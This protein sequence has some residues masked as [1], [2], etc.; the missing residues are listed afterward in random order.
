VNKRHIITFLM[1][2]IIQFLFIGC[3]DK[4]IDMGNIKTPDEIILDGNKHKDKILSLTAER[5]RLKQDGNNF[6]QLD[7]IQQQIMNLVV[8]SALYISDEEFIS[9]LVS[10]VKETKGAVKR[11]ID[12]EDQKLIENR[13]FF[14]AQFMYSKLQNIT[15]EEIKNGYISNITIL[16][17]GIAYVPSFNEGAEVGEETSLYKVQLSE[18]LIRYIKDYYESNL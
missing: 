5:N 12:T 7:E 3:K 18:E 1:I 2:I 4:N 17:N 8:Q 11:V 10:G 13:E 9:K 14:N 15:E 6:S 16:Y